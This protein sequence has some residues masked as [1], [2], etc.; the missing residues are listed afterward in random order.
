M[1][2]ALEDPYPAWFMDTQGIIR[3]ANLMAFWL[4]N[5]LKLTEPIRP[6]ALLDTSIFSIFANNFKRIPIEQ[7][8]EFFAKNSSMVK[9]MKANSI[10]ELPLYDNFIATMETEPLLERIYEEASLYS[11]YEWEH[12]LNIM[13]PGH[14]DSS[15]LLEFRVTV[16][17]LEGD[18]G[19]LCMY[20]PTGSTLGDVEEQ[21]GLLIEEYGDNA[22]VQ[23]DD[24]SQDTT[25]SN[26]I[27]FNFGTHFNTYYPSLIQD[28]LWYISGENK[29][30]Q[31]L[32]GSSV[33]GAHF[34]DLFFAP[35][36]HEWMGPIQETSAPR[37][38]KYFTE[39]TSTFLNEEHEFHDRYEQTMA[40]LMQLPDFRYMLG[41]SRKLPIRLYLPD[42]TEDWF[43]TYRLTM[44]VP[45]V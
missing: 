20:T 35:Q 16:Y 33:V 42:N 6:N 9:R 34:F 41:V 45:K 15:H 11:D 13:P 29:A 7:N 36:L 44:V 2:T 39:F 27:P 5:T 32:I 21:Y 10:V 3:G 28:P 30:Y 31:L 8:S 22:Y 38:I 37:A 1:R 4:W 19:F 23:L 24:P 40:R 18:S 43:Y 12:P 26:Q 25:E 14:M 17:R